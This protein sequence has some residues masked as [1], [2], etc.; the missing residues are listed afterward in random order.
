M[1]ERERRLLATP[2]G[3]ARGL[4][5]FKPYPKQSAVLRSMQAPGAKVAF[6]SCNEGGKTS[7]I[8]TSLI[9]WH[10]FAFPKGMVQ[11]TSG[12]WAQ[13]ISQLVPKL[14]SFAHK[15][16]RWRFLDK[17]ILTEHPAGFW[18]GISTN[19]AG[20]FEGAHADQDAPLLIIVDEAKTVADDIYEAI[21]RCRPTRLLLAS[22]TGESMGEFYRAFTSRSR[23]YT[24]LVSQT[25]EEC[26]HIPVKHVD[27]T[28]AKWGGRDSDLIKSMF[29]AEF[30]DQAGMGIIRA[31]HLER[32]M[33]NPPTFDGKPEQKGFCDFAAG[34]DENVFAVRRGNRVT[35]EDAWRDAD[36][37]AGVGRFIINYKRSGLAPHEIEGD[38]DGLG[39]PMC[40]ALAEAGWPIVFFHGG[41]PPRRD[42]HYANLWAEAW[43]EGANDIERG[44][45]SLPDDPE[46]RGQLLTRKRR[47]DRRGKLA[48]ESKE[49]MRKRG[50]PSPDRA[51]AVLG[52]MLPCRQARSISL[53][54]QEA[55][56]QLQDDEQESGG[57]SGFDSGW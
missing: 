20:R 28:T 25:V 8:I 19:D 13:I 50:V 24:A 3:F 49:D 38:A 21:E 36:T 5:G 27:E 56:A 46:L 54:Q 7:V 11:S 15:F 53:V 6:K 31:L 4:L 32:L 23:Y 1:N 12:S 14:K 48:L 29:W 52:V 10:L 33:A 30:M 37:M 9:L 42:E 16:P 41:K 57:R 39:K 44:L 51:D 2:E 45:W 34:G 22:S 35:I 55:V 26:P 40:D 18:R 43:Y 47:Y 17:E